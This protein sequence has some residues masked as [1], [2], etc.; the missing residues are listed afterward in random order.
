M[1]NRN[2]LVYG[3]ASA[4]VGYIFSIATGSIGLMLFLLGWFLNYKEIKLNRIRLHRVLYPLVLFFLMLAIGML[5]SLDIHQGKKD[6]IRILPF[7]LFPLIFGTIRP[8]NVLERKRILRIF[9]FS[10]SIFFVVCSVTALIRQI[11]FWGRGGDFNWYY[12]YRYDFLEVF[13]QHPTYLSVFT[14]LSL[15]FLLHKKRSIIKNGIWLNINITLQICA[16]FLY[17]SRIGYII[18]LLI[19]L[20]F[21]YVSFLGY[22]GKERIKRLVVYLL[23]LCLL[24]ITAWN[25]PI[26]KERILYTFGYSYNYEFND[27][28]F[29][30]DSS[31]EEKGRLLLWQD[32]WEL[33]IQKP[34]I[35]FGTGSARK[36]LLKKYE[37]KGHDLFLENRYN[38][39]NTYLEILLEGGI[40]LLTIYL[41]MLYTLLWNSFRRKN[42]AL[43]SFFLIITLTSITETIFLA[44]GIYFLS[45]F[46]CF[47]LAPKNE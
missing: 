36:I 3:S 9:I 41:A 47:L 29:I 10:L 13:N 22:G 6:V 23:I 34:A 19:T 12:F 18:F 27:K 42:F 25:V 7:L 11:G 26:I 17:G 44:Q 21:I 37:E 24:L 4:C 39:H 45:F 32:T 16:L 31:P 1:D 5:W 40:A 8:F 46:Y 35:G 15:T 38:A 14:L 30:K 20:I 43:F 28:E 2:I 33:I